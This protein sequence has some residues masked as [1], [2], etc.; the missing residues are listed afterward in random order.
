MAG[1]STRDQTIEE[2]Y[3]VPE[4]FLEVEVRNPQTHGKTTKSNMLRC[5]LT[6]FQ[7]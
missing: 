5:I 1:A 3:G 7:H 2:R 6:L 4:N